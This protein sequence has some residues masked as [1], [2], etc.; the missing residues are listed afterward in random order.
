LWANVYLNGFDHYVTRNLPFAGYIRYVDDLL[1]FGDDK[2]ALHD[3]LAA[4]ERRLATLRLRIHPG[5]HPRPVGEGIPFLGFVIFPERRR[6]KRRKGIHFRRR[7]RLALRQDPVDEKATA[8][9]V[10]GWRNHV[11]FANTAGLQKAVLAP[12]FERRVVESA[13]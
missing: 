3:G 1:F 9:A 10:Q 12:W 8:A 4:V 7:L 13:G 5:A 11:R 6:L 2:S